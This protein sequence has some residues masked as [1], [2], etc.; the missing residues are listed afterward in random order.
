M[1]EPEEGSSPRH[2]GQPALALAKFTLRLRSGSVNA[3]LLVALQEQFQVFNKTE[4]DYDHRADHADEEQPYEYLRD[5]LQDC[6]AIHAIYSIGRHS[7][8]SSPNPHP[9]I[10]NPHER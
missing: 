2:L 4:Y 5:V 3:G 6:G 1:A 8:R 7:S 10:H 9:F